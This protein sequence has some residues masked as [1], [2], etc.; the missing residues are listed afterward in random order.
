MEELFE[1]KRPEYPWQMDLPP[2]AHKAG[3]TEAERRANEARFHF[4]FWK[5][6]LDDDLF[7]HPD[8]F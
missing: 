6:L 1:S 5:G 4:G 3:M 8:L 2:W 7:D